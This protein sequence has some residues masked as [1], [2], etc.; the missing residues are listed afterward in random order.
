[1]NKQRIQQVLEIEKQ[2]QAIHD[3]AVHDAAQLQKQ[4]EQEAQALIEKTK[5]KTQKEA[6]SLVDDVQVE[7]ECERIMSQSEDKSHQMEA[8]AVEHF[9]RAV[10]YVLD[11]LVGRE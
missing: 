7:N 11:Q 3:A 2:A 6:Q 4:A 5:V 9:D 1:L 8:L 10:D